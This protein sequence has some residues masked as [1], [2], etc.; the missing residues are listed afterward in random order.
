MKFRKAVAMLAVISLLVTLFAIPAY[1]ATFEQN[2][3][4]GVEG[5]VGESH[6]PSAEE[7]NTT[8]AWKAYIGD[9][10]DQLPKDWLT[11]KNVWVVVDYDSA[12]APLIKAQ[13]SSDWSLLPQASAYASSSNKAVFKM[14]DLA[15]AYTA[16]GGNPDSWGNFSVRSGNDDDVLKVSKVVFYVDETPDLTGLTVAGESAAASDSAESATESANP[17]TGD[18]GG[19]VVAITALA[20]AGSALFLLRRKNAAE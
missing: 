11:K 14:E 13:D 15:A 17:A 8:N 12:V 3:A 18:N 9:F 7:W 19:I 16:A 2:I 5:C 6:L 4:N 10:P 1:A 20:L